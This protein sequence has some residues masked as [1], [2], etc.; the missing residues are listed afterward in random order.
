MFDRFADARV[1]LLG[2]ASHGTSECYRAR[3]AITRRLIEQAFSASSIASR[4]PLWPGIA[5]MFANSAWIPSFRNVRHGCL[6]QI[7]DPAIA[8]H[9]A[10][11]A[12][13]RTALYHQRVEIRLRKPSGY[14]SPCLSCAMLAALLFAASASARATTAARPRSLSACSASIFSIARALRACSAA[15]GGRS[16]HALVD[17]APIKINAVNILTIETPSWLPCSTGCGKVPR[18]VYVLPGR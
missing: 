5:Q 17:I 4:M 6:G 3:A 13:R 2:E 9:L 8:S 11:Q 18:D 10:Q 15:S 7:A 14:S 12:T 16:W 1:V